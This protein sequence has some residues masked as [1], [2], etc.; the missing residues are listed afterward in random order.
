MVKPV[1]IMKFPHVD[2]PTREK[3]IEQYFSIENKLYDYHVLALIDSSVEKITFECYN[4]PH[5]E[6]EFN[7]L[8]TELLKTLG[9]VK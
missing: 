7:E 5:T 1:F 9:S 8:K 3:L 4:S 2:E 6:K